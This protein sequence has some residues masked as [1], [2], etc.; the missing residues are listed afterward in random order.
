[1]TTRDISNLGIDSLTK[2]R[3]FFGTQ[4][5]LFKSF[6]V[7]INHVH[8]GHSEMTMPFSAT[9]ADGRG[10]LHR[11]VMVTLLD[12]CCG[13]S[14]FS[15][16]GTM[17]PIA[18]IDLRVDFLQEIPPATALIAVI[19]YV[20]RTPSIAYITGKAFAVGSHDPVATVAGS[21]AIGTMGPAFDSSIGDS[22]K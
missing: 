21:F 3:A 18:T 19:D 5:P 1:M 9:L 20:G 6:S 10:A 16:L 8:N 22:V 12:S 15:A 7:E 2:A 13:L 4:H 14:I 11:G 17:Q